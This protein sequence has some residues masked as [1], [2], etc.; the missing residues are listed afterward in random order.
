KFSSLLN[1]PQLSLA[2][3]VAEPLATGIQEFFAA[4]NAGM[5]LGLHDS[6]SEGQ[7]QD[8]YFA[9]IRYPSTTLNTNELF[10]VNDELHQGTSLQKTQPFQQADYMLFRVELLD[11]RDDWEGLKSIKEPFD[12][13]LNALGN[14][15]QA[16]QF[17][18]T[19][20]LRATRSPD[21]T[22]VDKRRVV[23]RLIEKYEEAKKVSEFRGATQRESQSLDQ[24]MRNPLNVK[25][26][27]AKGPPLPSEIFAAIKDNTRVPFRS[28]V[29]EIA[30]SMP[31]VAPPMPTKKRSTRKLG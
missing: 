3:N 20:L 25:V 23:D 12:D 7:L 24:I 5:H 4:A 21:L 16:T 2:L 18:R 19:A 26:A 29:P 28:P 15:D 13:A 31:E 17:M 8:G 11:K 30:P 6:F 9:A 14:K 22:D 1:V 10:V 27:L